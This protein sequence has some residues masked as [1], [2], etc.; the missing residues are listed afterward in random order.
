MQ[1]QTVHYSKKRRSDELKGWMNRGRDFR[2][3]GARDN[4]FLPR[5][6]ERVV[7]WLKE[8][9]LPAYEHRNG[10]KHPALE[11]FPF[12]FSKLAPSKIEDDKLVGE[13][14]DDP[15]KTGA[16]LFVVLMSWWEFSIH[17]RKLDFLKDPEAMLYQATLISLVRCFRAVTVWRR[18]CCY[19]MEVN[20][21]PVAK[22]AA[23]LKG[24]R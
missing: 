13:A 12:T 5:F 11:N 10:D 19:N 7:E 6:G 17:R 18:G 23:M 21:E 3:E 1:T 9:L 16:V 14:F 4:F 20:N 8:V 15:S 2:D 22:K 24:A